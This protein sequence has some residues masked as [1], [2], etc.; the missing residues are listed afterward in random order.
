MD[1]HPHSKL[2]HP[3]PNLPSEKRKEKKKSKKKELCPLIRGQN[4]RHPI[5][6]LL[7]KRHFESFQGL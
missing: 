5:G 2:P 7:R 1:F 3:I 4:P 6:T